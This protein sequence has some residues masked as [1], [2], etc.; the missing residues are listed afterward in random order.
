VPAAGAV[1]VRRRALC[2]PLDTACDD[3]NKSVTKCEADQASCQAKFLIYDA[4]LQQIGLGVTLYS[5]PALYRDE[6]AQYYPAANPA[7]VRFGCS[8]RQPPANAT[9]DCDRIYFND[10][11]YVETV[12]TG[13]L[14]HADNAA[15]RFAGC[16]MS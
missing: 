1:R 15:H 13:T 2:T 10:S 12:R 16:C 5:L 11:G 9:T 3:Y 4:Y 14:K 7:Q 6:L 8:N